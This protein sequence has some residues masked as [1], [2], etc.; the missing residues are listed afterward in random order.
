MGV[1]GA[2]GGLAC[3]AG[4]TLL[5][6]RT[7]PADSLPPHAVIALS[8][9][10]LAFAVAV[11]TLAAIVAT[12]APGWRLGRVAAAGAL[13]PTRTVAG[14]RA[15]SRARAMLVGVEVTLAF[16]LAAAAMLFA[17]TLVHLQHVDLGLMPD[18]LVATSVSLDGAN[19]S[20]AEARTAFFTSLTSERSRR[21][22]A[23]PR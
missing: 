13:Q 15:S 2:G 5:L 17:R 1:L 19:Q 7:L 12:L 4:G 21:C 23:C 22:Q 11:A 3:A 8:P 14:S 20:S 16:V 18:R 6:A 10:V 9:A